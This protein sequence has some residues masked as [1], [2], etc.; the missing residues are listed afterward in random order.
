MSIHDSPTPLVRVYE[1]QPSDRRP[2]GSQAI[3]ENQS[4]KAIE[5][6]AAIWVNPNL[7]KP[8]G[9]PRRMAQFTDSF[10]LSGV[11]QPVVA[12]RSRAFIGPGFVTPKRLTESGAG[13]IGA[14]PSPDAAVPGWTLTIDAILSEDGALVGP[15]TLHL[16]ETI[17]V[18]KTV[19]TKVTAAVR[20]AAANHEDL[21]VVFAELTAIPPELGSEIIASPPPIEVLMAFNELRRVV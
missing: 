20:K 13:Y 5:G 8:N 6:L 15:D 7:A 17:I 4:D 18:R 14:L 21:S 16:R 9:N 1:I 11:L 12:S 19:A 10:A 2:H 3:I